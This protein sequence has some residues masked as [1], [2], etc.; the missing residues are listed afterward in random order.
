MKKKLLSGLAVIVAMVLAFANQG[1]VSAASL[2]TTINLKLGSTLTGTV[3]LATAS[4]SFDQSYVKTF[5]N[6]VAASQADKVYSVQLAITTAATQDIDLQGSL[7]DALGAA[8]TPLKLK[9]LYIESAAA[10]TTNLTLFGDANSVPILN[11]A[12]TTMTLQPGG[13]FFYC[14]PPL[15][16]TTVTAGTGDIIQI[17]NAAGATATVNVVVIGT[18]S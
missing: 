10:N 13:V 3:G 11:T 2:N 14:N 9:C 16:A 15:A 1:D 7:T 17:V 12:A 4:A 5:A 8:F 6:G 18:S